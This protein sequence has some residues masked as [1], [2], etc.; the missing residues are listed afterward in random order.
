MQKKHPIKAQKSTL[1]TSSQNPKRERSPSRYPYK[2][3][4]DLKNKSVKRSKSTAGRFSHPE[5]LKQW[6]AQNSLRS[7]CLEH[8]LNLTPAD[9]IPAFVHTSYINENQVEDLASYERVEFLG[10]AVIGLTIAEYLFKTFPAQEEGW[11]S[12]MRGSLVNEAILAQLAKYLGLHQW[13]IV[14]KG[15]AETQERAGLLADCYEALIGVIFLRRGANFAKK[16]ILKSFFQYEQISGEK[17]FDLDRLAQFDPRTQVQELSLKKYKSL[18]VYKTITLS[19]GEN[20]G[21][22]QVSLLINDQLI[23]TTINASK[24]RAIKE[25]AAFALEK[26]EQIFTLH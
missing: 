12:K 13:I 16:F 11:L 18:P 1:R 9:L 6:L 26:K 15:V 23:H 21:Q 2:V 25:L 20:E 8:Q 10:D 19:E 14:G 22:Y 5:F 7:F 4:A 24:K 17:L 3:I